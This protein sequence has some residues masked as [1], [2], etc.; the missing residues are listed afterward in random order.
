MI[1]GSYTPRLVITVWVGFDNNFP[2]FEAAKGFTESELP[3]QIW[4]KFMKDV[5]KYRPDLLKDSF[6]T[7]G[8]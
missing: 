7:V 6:A 8:R 3:V 1:F 2:A 5:K 4:T